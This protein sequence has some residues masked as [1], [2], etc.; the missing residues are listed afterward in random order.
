MAK[1]KRQQL[2]EAVRTQLRTI[3]IV[4]GF[5]TDAGRT[6]YLGELVNLGPDD[7]ASAIAIVVGD[8]QVTEQSFGPATLEILLPFSVVGLARADLSEPWIAA[9]QTIS[10]VK[11]VLETDWYVGLVQELSRGP[12]RTL[13]REEGSDSIG[14]GVEYVA[15]IHEDWGSP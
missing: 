10:D 5:D 13:E 4:D 2:F 9:E 8:D 15:L 1:S 3:K 12:T 11:K 14:I 6:V 7:P